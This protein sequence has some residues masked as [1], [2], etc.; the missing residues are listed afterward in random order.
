MALDPNTQAAHDAQV[1]SNDKRVAADA[2]ATAAAKD[3]AAKNA[4]AVKPAT[5]AEVAIEAHTV[6]TT[7]IAALVAQVRNGA[8]IA[9]SQIE[10]LLGKAEAAAAGIAA[11]V[12]GK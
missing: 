7:D 2:A 10:A 6:L 3:A 8:A 11:A 5:P 4:S 12:K 1:A 9:L